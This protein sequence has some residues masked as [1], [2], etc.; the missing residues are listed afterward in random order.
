MSEAAT[1]PVARPGRSRWLRWLLIASLA[2]NALV[3]GLVVR[4]VW[5][6]RAASMSVVGGLDARLP[7]FVDTLPPERR[8]ALRRLGMAD[9]PRQLR[10]LRLEVRRARGDVMRAFL[11]EPFDKQALSKAQAAALE[12]EIRLRTAV[13]E[14]L[15]EIGERMTP[16]ERRALVGWRAPGFGGPGFGPGRRGPRGPE[17][18][19][20]TK[21]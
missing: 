20:L 10:P 9:R 14:I 3:I 18:E 4:S 1:P 6:M 2:F 17:P 15:P 11:A 5:H 16:A 21:P 7:G 8:D 19:T 13:Q 12:A